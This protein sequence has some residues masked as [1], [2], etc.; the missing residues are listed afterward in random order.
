MRQ[1]QIFNN[2]DGVT[3]VE[4]MVA[5]SI[6]TIA[7]GGILALASFSFV[8]TDLAS[9]NLQASALAKGTIEALRNYRDGIAWDNDDAG[10]EYDG[11][12]VLS[13]GV[14]YYPEISGDA[15]PRWKFIQGVE[16]T[17]IFER[18]VVFEN[19]ERDV[20]D[21]ITESGGVVD[22]NTKKATVIVSWEERGRTHSV[23]LVSYFTNWNK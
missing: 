19:V 7:L 1:L 23:D 13:V 2:K 9:Q 20:L 14:Q 22:L 18:S 16:T 21:T 4:I 3:V 6:L 11:L 12:G 17:G 10:N 15:I 8:S 5:V